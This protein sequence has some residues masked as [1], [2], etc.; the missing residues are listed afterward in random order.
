MAIL[1]KDADGKVHAL[2]AKHRIKGTPPTAPASFVVVINV[3]GIDGKRHQKRGTARTWTDADAL[4][5][6]FLN[7]RDGGA[8]PAQQRQEAGSAPKTVAAFL[9]NWIAN[10]APN[11]GGKKKAPRTLKRY[12][13]LVTEP[14]AVDPKRKGKGPRSGAYVTRTIGK[15]RL[16]EVT[17]DHV[18]KLYATMR[19]AGISD[20][21]IL[22][23]HRALSLAFKHARRSKAITE[24]PLSPE[25]MDPPTAAVHEIA[26]PTK[27]EARIILAEAAKTQ[28]GAI[29]FV[30]AHTG[31]RQA[32]LINLKWSNVD[33][34]AGILSII[35]GKTKASRRPIPLT[36]ATI[37]ALR[38]HRT[39][40]R[41]ERLRL[42]P[43]WHDSGLV[44][45]DSRGG[46][47]DASNLR[48]E[49]SKICRDV[50][51]TRAANGEPKVRWHDLRHMVATRLLEMNT[52]VKA[53][54]A[55]LGHSRSAVTLDTYSH[56][57]PALAIDA[58]T[59]AKLDAVMA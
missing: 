12:R 8:L 48:R 40:Q 10:V 1:G 13:E 22:N 34:D 26:P 44:F 35:A 37:E 6:A 38:D 36:K 39:R 17:P 21:T 29:T 50:N 30:A 46:R 51:A 15:M 2:D 54:S 19:T 25:L 27:A 56:V 31:A 11:Q 14:T 18:L 5:R 53:V 20:K 43:I 23:T 9:D 58:E 28:Y 49:W 16:G 55:L 47:I 59:A 32:E 24:N 42:G 4:Q 52:H 41:E 45:T 57:S 3:N 7:Q 33:L